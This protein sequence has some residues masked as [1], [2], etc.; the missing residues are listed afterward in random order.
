MTADAKTVTVME[1]HPNLKTVTVTVIWGKSILKNNK[2][3]GNNFDSNGTVAKTPWQTPI[4]WI[5]QAFCLRKKRPD[6]SKSGGRSE[7]ARCSKFTIIAIVV[8]VLVWKGPFNWA[9]KD[10]VGEVAGLRELSRLDGR[11][12]N[13][14]DDQGNDI[15]CRSF[16]SMPRFL[17]KGKFLTGAGRCIKFPSYGKKENQTQRRSTG[18]H[19]K[20]GTFDSKH[21][22]L[23]WRNLSVYS[24]T[25]LA[26]HGEILP[27]TWVIH[28]ATCRPAH[29]TPIHMDLEPF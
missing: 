2:T 10:S 16:R 28:M 29:N 26:G 7:N 6:R 21:P 12:K 5:L 1:I 25:F 3:A 11:S 4:S 23:G 8:L 17:G 15:H 19:R 20:T 9:P 18:Q 27:P 24:V 13:A 22:F 14:E